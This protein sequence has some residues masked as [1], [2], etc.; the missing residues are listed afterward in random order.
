MATPTPR[1]PLLRHTLGRRPLVRILI[2][3]GVVLV[4][5]ALLVFEPWALVIDRRVDEAAPAPPRR[6][7]RHPPHRSSSPAAS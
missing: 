2:V 6:P 4:A 7:P 3:A 5:A 1:R